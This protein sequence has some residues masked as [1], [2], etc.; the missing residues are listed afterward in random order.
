M[1]SSFFWAFLVLFIVLFFDNSV[2]YSIEYRIIQNGL[3]FEKQ[4]TL[5]MNQ[6]VKLPED[7]RVIV[8]IGDGNFNISNTINI[9]VGKHYVTFIGSKNTIISGSIEVKG[10]EILDNGIWRSRIPNG[11]NE[12]YMPDQLYVNGV[13][14]IRARTPNKGA[15]ILVEGIVKGMLYGAKL[16]LR[17]MQLIKSLN[18]DEF[19][20]LSIYRKWAV[21]KRMLVNISHI[22]NVL[23]FSGKKFP[24]HN[25]LEK[26]NKIIIENAKECM[27]Q[28]GEWY[29]DKRGFLYYMPKE[30]EDIET[31]N[32]KI[33]VVEK[34]LSIKSNPESSGRLCFKNLVFEHTTYQSP[35]G[36]SD[37][38]QAAANVSAAIEIDNIRNFSIQECEIRNTAN[39]GLWFRHNCAYSD[40]INTFFHDLG[41]GAIKIGEVKQSDDNNLT[42]NITIENN[43]IYNYGTH[44]ESAVGIILFNAFNCKISHNDIHCGNYTGISVGWVWGYG[45]SPSKNNEISYNRLSHI[46]DGRLNDLGGIYTLGKSEGTSIHHN[47][48]SNVCSGDFRGWGIY[49]D[50]GTTGIKVEK[51]IVFHST[52]GGFHQHYGSGNVVTNNIFAWGEYSQFTLTSVRENNPL[53][54]ENNIIIMD[55]GNLMSGDGINSN[56]FVVRQNCYWD[57]A[58]ESQHV[59]KYG[60]ILWAIHRDTTS[61]VRD[62]SFRNAITGDFRFKNR[63]ICKAISFEEFDYNKAG[64]Y[65]KR[66]VGKK[67][68]KIAY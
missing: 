41:A 35:I 54:F 44:I 34:L 22:D 63:S 55:T 48:I 43:V 53:T 47:V 29:V 4:I 23:Y 32:F 14:A 12:K 2:A 8:K 30:H 62:P 58:L 28:P 15:F 31:T 65:G 60:S 19:P 39:Y 33:P 11:L 13:R 59:D 20:I 25:M 61:V 1:K 3:P 38:D 7:E 52:S 37:F 24:S 51:N 64:V 18:E 27:D 49:A 9:D 36:E 45:S 50:E 17:D 6:I 40:V 26:G 46:G 42:N 57:I 5:I 56:K 67:R 68:L 21:S 10:W 66:M 16:N